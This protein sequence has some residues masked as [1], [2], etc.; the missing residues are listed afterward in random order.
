MPGFRDPGVT[1]V[2]AKEISVMYGCVTGRRTTEISIM[3]GNEGVIEH[4][5]IFPSIKCLEVMSV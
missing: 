5:D 2:N 3:Y 1:I 4:E